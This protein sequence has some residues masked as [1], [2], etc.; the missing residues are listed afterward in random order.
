M[1]IHNLLSTLKGAINREH[2]GTKMSGYTLG[3]DASCWLHKGIYSCSAELCRG[4]NT[5]AYV[6]YC[7]KNVR[8]LQE[9]GIKLYIV[10]DGDDLPMKKG[11]L[12]DRHAKRQKNLLRAQQL[13]KSGD[14]EGA[15]KCYNSAVDVTPEMGRKFMDALD[16]HRVP[17]VVAPYEADSQLAHMARSKVIDG[18]ITEDSDLVAYGVSHVWFKWD[19]ETLMADHCDFRKLGACEKIDLVNM[20]HRQFLHLCILSGCDY[21]DSLPGVGMISACKLIRKYP[22]IDKLVLAVRW[23]GDKKIPADYLECFHRAF[24]TFMH[25]RVWCTQTNRIVHVNDLPSNVDPNKIDYLGP[26][27]NHDIAEGICHGDLNPFTQQP[28]IKGAST[29]SSNLGIGSSSSS[30]SRSRNS[31]S[32][33][34]SSNRSRSSKQKSL[35]NGNIADYLKPSVKVLQKPF[36]APK[37]IKNNNR[38]TSTSRSTARNDND[39][40]SSRTRQLANSYSQSEKSG[41]FPQQVTSSSIQSNHSKAAPEEEEEEEEKDLPVSSAS[42]SSS[43]RNFSTYESTLV[44]TNFNSLIS[45]KR[46]STSNSDVFKKFK[47]P[48]TETEEEN[49]VNGSSAYSSTSSSSSSSSSD[50]RHFDAPATPAHFQ[51]QNTMVNQISPYLGCQNTDSITSFQ[52]YNASSSIIPESPPSLRPSLAFRSFHSN[53]NT[54]NITSFPSN[55]QPVTPSNAF[56]DFAYNKNNTTGN[57]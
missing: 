27:M 52:S 51:Q 16:E 18:V 41:Y 29:Y 53:A 6:K 5:T 28:M 19:R 8:V 55:C 9:A 35:A 46:T 40:T 26:P 39:A 33:S 43:S 36:K 11:T 47:R 22:S 7:M 38:H 24:M 12:K 15:R 13:E 21:L 20:E 34:S 44:S 49:Q 48:R 23:Q 31:S 3:V 50:H 54:N 4:E 56:A 32:S 1:G 10:F 14:M 37:M 25:A 42:A 17:Y 2:I 30:S 57:H 45:V